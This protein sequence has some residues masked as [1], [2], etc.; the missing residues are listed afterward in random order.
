MTDLVDTVAEAICRAHTG[1]DAET[2]W[3][4]TDWGPARYR[5]L[6][7]V[8]IDT[9]SLALPCCCMGDCLGSKAGH[10]EQCP[11]SA[12]WPRRVA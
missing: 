1:E 8:A 6:A 7:R 2:V 12:H 5:E 3:N 9:L 11:K 10:H 4:A